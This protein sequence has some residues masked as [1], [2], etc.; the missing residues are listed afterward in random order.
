MRG[1]VLNWEVLG[2]LC[3]PSYTGLIIQLSLPP[4]LLARLGSPQ[5]HIGWEDGGC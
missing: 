2:L 1:A 3:S 5:Q 4:L